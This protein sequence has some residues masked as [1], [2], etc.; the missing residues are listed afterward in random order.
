[1]I[2][3]M[4]ALL[5]VVMISGC[6]AV[7]PPPPPPLPLQLAGAT[8]HDGLLQVQWDDQLR[9]VSAAGFDS[10]AAA[11]AC[12]QLGWL[13]GVA[14]FSAADAADAACHSFEG[15]AAGGACPDAVLRNSSAGLSDCGTSCRTLRPC[16]G[17]VELHCT[18][19]RDPPA[20]PVRLAGGRSER[21]GRVEVYMGGAWGR[22]SNL[23]AAAAGV[24]CRQ[25]G[26]GGSGRASDVP[27]FAPPAEGLVWLA[28]PH[29]WGFEGSLLECA[30][31]RGA[32]AAPSA[33]VSCTDDG[34][35]PTP[36][37]RLANASTAGGVSSGV[38]QMLLHGGWR[39]LD[40]STDFDVV[41]AATVCKQLGLLS[42]VASW[43]AA[44][45]EPGEPCF[46]FRCTKG[47][48]DPCTPGDAAL[49]E[50]GR[51]GCITLTDCHQPYGRTREWAA[52]AVSCGAGTEPPDGS[53]AAP[54]VRLAG[55]RAPSE[56]R[57]EVWSQQ[58]NAWGRA[59]F[60]NADAGAV[61]CR[62]LGLGEAS[63]VTDA[64]LVAPQWAEEQPVGGIVWSDR[65]T[66]F[67]GLH[68][69]LAECQPPVRAR[70]YDATASY[71][72]PSSQVA[73]GAAPELVRLRGHQPHAGVVEVLWGG[74]WR[75]LSASNVDWVVASTICLQLG[76]VG[77]LASLRLCVPTAAP[78]SP[79]NCVRLTSAGLCGDAPKAQLHEC[80]AAYFVWEAETCGSGV[81]VSCSA[82][83]DLPEVQAP[84]TLRLQ[85]GRSARE[86]RLE[87]FSVAGSW[88]GIW[89]RAVGLDSTDAGVACRE[90]GLGGR[91][92]ATS[93]PLFAPDVGGDTA[94]A[95]PACGGAEKSLAMCPYTA[96]GEGGSDAPGAQ[97][98]CLHSTERAPQVL[99]LVNGSG[100]HEGVLQMLYQGRWYTWASTA[101]D[102]SLPPEWAASSAFNRLEAA[103]ACRQLGFV[104]GTATFRAS[105]PATPGPCLTWGEIDSDSPCTADT[106][107]L[108]ECAPA[109]IQPTVC[110]RAVALACGNSTDLPAVPLRLVGG[111]NGRE[112]RL[113]VFLHSIFGKAGGLD[114]VAAGVACR[115]MGKGVR[116]Y[117]SQAPLFSPPTNAAVWLNYPRCSSGEASLLDCP[118]ASDDDDPFYELETHLVCLGAGSRPDV[119]RLLGGPA[120]NAGVVHMLWE[121]EWRALGAASRF[122]QASADVACSQLGFG[123]PAAFSTGAPTNTSA[124]LVNECVDACAGGAPG[125]HECGDS[126]R[127]YQA[128]TAD[129][130]CLAGITVTCPLPPPPPLPLPPPSPRPPYPR[131]PLPYP[132]RPPPLPPPAPAGVAFQLVAPWSRQAF[133]ATYTPPTER[134]RLAAVD[135]ACGGRCLSQRHRANFAARLSATLRVPRS[136]LAA[137]RLAASGSARLVVSGEVLVAF[138]GAQSSRQG[139]ILISKGEHEVVVESSRQ[140]SILISKGEHEVVVEFLHAG[141]GPSSLKLAWKPKGGASFQ[142][143][144]LVDRTMPPRRPPPACGVE[145]LPDALVGAVLGFAGV[146]EG[147]SVTLV[148][149]RWRHLFYAEPS[150]WRRFV[151]RPGSADGWLPA[152]H[153]LLAHVARL[154]E[155]LHVFDTRGEQA[156]A[157]AALHWDLAVPQLGLEAFLRLLPR[158]GLTVLRLAV[159][160][161]HVGAQL[162][163]AALDFPQLRHL[164]LGLL[165]MPPNLPGLLRQL[166]LSRF[167]A[168]CAMQFPAALFDSLVQQPSLRAL[169]LTTSALLHAPQLA[170]LTALASLHSLMLTECGARGDGTTMQPPPLTAFPHLRDCLLQ[171]G[172]PTALEVEGARM[173]ALS[174]GK[175]LLLLI[176]LSSMPSLEHLLAQLP[177]LA[178]PVACLTFSGVCTLA[179]EA[180]A[181]QADTR[182]GPSALGIVALRHCGDAFAAAVLPPLLEQARRIH[183]VTL[184][185]CELG[186]LPPDV[187]LSGLL[188]LMLDQRSLPPQLAGASNL[189]ILEF[190]QQGLTLEAVELLARLPNLA[191]LNLRAVGTPPPA[192]VLRALHRRLPHLNVMLRRSPLRRVGRGEAVNKRRPAAAAAAPAG[193]RETQLALAT[194]VDAMSAE[195][196]SL[197][198]QLGRLVLAGGGGARAGDDGGSMADFGPA[199]AAR[200][201]SQAAAS[202]SQAAPQTSAPA[203]VERQLAALSAK[204]GQLS[205][206]L[207]QLQAG[208]PDGTAAAAADEGASSAR[209]HSGTTYL[210]FDTNVW[211][212]HV[213]VIRECWKRLLASGGTHI[214]LLV[215]L[216]VMSELDGIKRCLLRG[217]FARRAIKK[218][219]DMQAKGGELL[220]GQR[221]AE[222]H[223]GMRRLRDDGILDCLLY[224]R[225]RGAQVE[226]VTKDTG[227]A[228]R[229]RTEGIPAVDQEQARLRLITRLAD[230]EKGGK[231]GSR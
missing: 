168:A 80:G 93:F 180:A 45:I 50:C 55:G 3:L 159:C 217:F 5:T 6:G 111:R 209:E 54:F 14:L 47:W 219:A 10:T 9:K 198:R 231:S 63:L 144:P 160:T 74:A 207:G 135:V 59:V 173:E 88:Q 211:M 90:L 206:C 77:G 136:G 163:A 162:A 22:A 67:R 153:A 71:Y 208:E 156:G 221:E 11:V 114:Q 127:C 223:R 213:K 181:L 39:A 228:V 2:T 125:L 182:L 81:E 126:S 43:D 82:S 143:L 1:M 220:R 66:C 24:L 110:G 33:Q 215:P 35:P 19:G 195:A 130:A 31:G 20:V 23:S 12:R 65:P 191:R 97:L 107:W 155:E 57:V 229:A 205:L 214:R 149:K 218:L 176:S 44:D 8:P 189:K 49:H 7:P 115:Q 175:G 187:S 13:G 186:A 147:R 18:P 167:K 151:L 124:C 165:S 83:R 32:G 201:P 142:A 210:V 48:Q 98:A 26:L 102:D 85:G 183:A 53:A 172:C 36:T 42:G 108:H 79:D 154:V 216:A 95:N 25:L 158:G 60:L 106:P 199:T 137:F 37:L 171:A 41:A 61:V 117:A 194:L 121:G 193:P 62:E 84:A 200:D 132:R 174:I 17:A 100:P 56:G 76:W 78:T 40:L 52:M 58:Y 75:N 128:R 109:S 91:G 188:Q 140:G 112:G 73:C 87:L 169:Q 27:L 150:L 99:R 202:P 69:S 38:V 123:L 138:T 120:P 146:A 178:G 166:S 16:V 134:G 122:D 70:S 4:L 203:D 139:S 148:C 101:E 113:E 51:P 204:L 116:G 152:K 89:R 129:E 212:D 227:L 190:H 34:Q 46:A 29:C 192:R 185:G 230:E 118:F 68:S 196:A 161:Q 15:C 72:Q 94:L 225:E 30:G 21:E 105:V 64:P 179:A 157:G 177:P 28:G 131:P 145:A 92:F 222:L 164:E 119:V 103:V 170:A 96:A 197:H 226:L 184:T 104:G 224:F 133:P 141:A 86:G